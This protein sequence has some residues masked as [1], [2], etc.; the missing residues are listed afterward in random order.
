MGQPK[1]E[2]K[3]YD[4]DG[5]GSDVVVR[6]GLRELRIEN[7]YLPIYYEGYHFDDPTYWPNRQEVKLDGEDKPWVW[8]DGERFWA[9]DD[10]QEAATV[11]VLRGL[12]PPGGGSSHQGRVPTE[13]GTVWRFSPAVQG[14]VLHPGEPDGPA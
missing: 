14:T 10:P 9:A 5:R 2:L 11:R 6:G 13:E 7:N 4:L 8:R 3:V 1:F 12:H